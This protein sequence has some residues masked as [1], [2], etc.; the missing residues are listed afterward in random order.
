MSRFGIGNQKEMTNLVNQ[1]TKQLLKVIESLHGYIE[2]LTYE[3]IKIR[4][5]IEDKSPEIKT[6]VSVDE[7]IQAH[8]E[9]IK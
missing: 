4:L 7:I 5:M 6:S 9:R 3:T 1:S 2:I 8:Q